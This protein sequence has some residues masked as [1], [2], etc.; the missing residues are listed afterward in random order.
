M[1]GLAK[2]NSN[3]IENGKGQFG[4]APINAKIAF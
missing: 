3:V 2:N 4:D 1:A